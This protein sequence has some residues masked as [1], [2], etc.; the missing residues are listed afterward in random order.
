MNGPTSDKKICGDCGEYESDCHCSG[1]RSALDKAQQRIKILDQLNIDS[2]HDDTEIRNL[3]RPI[4]GD[5]ATDG[6]SYGMPGVVDLVEALVAN[7]AAREKALRKLL[8]VSN[9]SLTE[10]GSGRTLWA[11]FVKE[12]CD[13]ALAL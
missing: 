9:Q 1:L 10:Y 5:F 3:V 2:C 7:L 4:L 13:A 8:D 11:S 12:I 6:D